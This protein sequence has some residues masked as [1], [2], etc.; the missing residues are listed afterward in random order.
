M[1]EALPAQG[2]PLWRNPQ[3]DDTRCSQRQPAK[4]KLSVVGILGRKQA[5]FRHRELKDE[6]IAAATERICNE[7]HVMAIR[8]KWP[9]N[10]SRHAFVGDPAHG[11]QPKMN[12]SLRI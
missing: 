8:A 5:T 6:F 2:V 7:Q 10:A 4:W 11:D 3:K 12:S 1:L 9:N